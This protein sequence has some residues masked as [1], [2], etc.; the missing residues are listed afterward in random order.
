MSMKNTPLALHEP[1]ARAVMLLALL[2]LGGCAMHW[3]WRHRAPPP[4]QSVHQ[5]GVAAEDG[6]PMPALSQFWD[7]NTLLLDLT[8]MSASGGATLT[9]IKAL[10]WPVRL[11]FKVRPGSIARLEVLADQ[12]VVYTV[13]SQGPPTLLKLGP[14]V[15]HADTARI[16][17]RWSGA[18]GS[19]P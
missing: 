12:R 13:A 9:P 18:D 19:A 5:V 4:P 1:A 10:G 2:S 16:T 17:L 15:Y 3:P 6:G 14:G 7:R 11:E 8:A